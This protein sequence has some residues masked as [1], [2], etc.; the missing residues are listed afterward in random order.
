MRKLFDV[1][2][3]M[4]IVFA[5]N[6]VAVICPIHAEEPALP[7]ATSTSAAT[8]STPLFPLDPLQFHIAALLDADKHPLKVGSI[9][10]AQGKFGPALKL[11]FTAT[12]SGAF[13]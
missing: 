10:V 8:S 6:F 9:E 4:P 7:H 11:S 3:P 2:G 12:Q 5:L 1:A 13:M